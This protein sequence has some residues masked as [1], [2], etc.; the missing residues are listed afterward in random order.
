MVIKEGK[1]GKCVPLCESYVPVTVRLPVE[2]TC[3][4]AFRFL[5]LYVA[6]GWSSGS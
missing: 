3:I 5:I 4:V 6:A 2:N 1:Q